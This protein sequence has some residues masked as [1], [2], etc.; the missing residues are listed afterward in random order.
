MDIYRHVPGKKYEFAEY[1]VF[2]SK[3]L[4]SLNV[5]RYNLSRVNFWLN[6][7][8]IILL[9]SILWAYIYL[10]F[11]RYHWQAFGMAT[12]LIVWF[13]VSLII[14]VTFRESTL[15]TVL[16]ALNSVSLFGMLIVSGYSERMRSMRLRRGSFRDKLQLLSEQMIN[17]HSNEQ[18]YEQLLNTIMQHDDIKI[19]QYIINDSGNLYQFNKNTQT[20]AKYKLTQQDV[21]KLI[22]K[23]VVM[24]EDIEIASSIMQENELNILLPVKR[25]TAL[26]GLI[27]LNMQNTKS[28]LNK[29]DIQIIQTIANQM[30]IAIENNN[31]IKESAELVKQLT[32]S[33]IR[34]EYLKKLEESNQALDKKNAE[35]TR[36]FK[37]LQD[38]EAQLIHSEKMASLG[39]LVAGISHELNNP[40]SFIY[41]NSKTL[42]E[43]IEEI[44][45]LW[46]QLDQTKTNKIGAEFK[47]ILAELKSMVTDNIKGSQSVN[48]LVLNLKNFSRLDQAEWKDANLV[49]GIESSLKLLKSHIPPDIVIETKIES[50]PVLYCNPGQLNQV[51]INLISNAA[52]AIHGPGKISIVSFVKKN[53]LYIE[54]EDNGE[55]I[56]KKVLPKI[57]D[58]FFT[59]KEINKGTGLGLSISYSIIEKHGGQLKVK[60]TKGKGSVF[61]II[62]PVEGPKIKQNKEK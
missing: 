8:L 23:N 6:I 20:T 53:D 50:D 51:F 29:E 1:N 34:E 49:S 57:F 44:E 56:D 32:E 19:T 30:A 24:Y 47:N 42:K 40:I 38:K 26:F 11:N 58:P 39:Q 48:D 33:K 5:I 3:V 9:L 25:E 45:Q 21:D 17:F 61:T 52:Q 62:L 15:Y 31:Y 18:L 4:F 14:Y 28:P 59:T 27:G 7:S 36:L 10:G 37:E 16:I 46:N 22:Q 41:A 54:I 13:V 12:Q 2:I 55:G 35:L 43:S 60:S